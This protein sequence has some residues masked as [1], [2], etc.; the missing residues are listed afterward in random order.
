MIQFVRNYDDLSTD[1]GFQFSFH[2]DKCGNGYMS[3]FQPNTL[4]IAGGLLNAAGSIFGG[5]FSEAGNATYQ[6]QRAIGGKS[7]DD[8]L[9]KAVQEG[10]THFHQC[11]RCGQWV[12]PDVCW[13]GSVGLCESCAPDEKEELAAQQALAASQQI[14]QKTR[15]TDYTNHIDFKQRAAVVTCTNCSAKLG[16][17]D[18]FCPACGTPNAQS[19]QPVREKFCANCGAK[20]KTDQKFC[21]DC[22][23]G[24]A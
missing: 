12:C 22:G 3:R 13:N 20:A 4:G 7:H 1:K 10:K 5:I 17:A 11:T 19:A 6:M 2:C 16:P 15:E 8:A 14:Y 24:L 9:E 23:T 18:K 21:S